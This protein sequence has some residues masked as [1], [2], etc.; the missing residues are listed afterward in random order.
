MFKIKYIIG[1]LAIVMATSSCKKWLEVTPRTEIT[2]D[3][4][5]TTQS[6]YQDALTGVYIQMKSTD[7]YGKALTMGTIENIIS[8]WDVT[9]NTAEQR[10]GLYDFDDLN[11][12]AAINS[13]YKQQYKIIA[14]AN[15]ILEKIDDYQNIFT[16]AGMYEL[17]KAECLAIR[18]YCH[19]DLLRLFGPLPR[20]ISTSNI[21]PYVKTFSKIPNP[22]VSY[23]EFKV[24][25]LNDMTAAAQLFEEVD[26]IKDYSLL[27][28]G[29]PGAYQSP[30]N[31]GDAYAAFRYIRMNYYAVKAMQ[32]RAYLWFGQNGDAYTA[33][34]VVMDA[35]NPDNSVKFRLGTSADMVA[36]DLVLTP[37]HIVSLHDYALFNKY[38][39]YFLAGNLKKGSS[40]AT[41][42]T[43]L[44]GNTATDMRELY[45]W[46]LLTLP[47][48]SKVYTTHKYKSTETVATVA[49]DYRRIPLIRISEMY[50]IAIETAAPAEAQALW[51]A[52]STSRNI[53][54]PAL[55]D[56][57]SALEVFLAREYRKEFF[58]EG[59]SFY[60]YKRFNTD[61]PNVLFT[62]A[63]A[64]I[65]YVVPLPLSEFVQ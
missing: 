57:K 44:Y 15:A 64:T 56:T 30:F 12:Q 20:N 62:P 22:H 41:I 17:I 60:A 42:K 45:L 19:F 43:S 27:D 10:L 5:L 55:P 34:K 65:N 29:R 52:F 28:L 47:N 6:G 8:S 61:K 18:A 23:N 35:R 11:A 40:A 39:D 58:A 25:L 63:A 51:T 32:A 3:D 49:T 50:L 13:L 54:G 59:Q 46:E 31:P 48:Q 1:C 2:K 38:N 26:P 4:M 33:A 36:N 9:S 53:A 14:G 7:A 24:Q 37:E 16:T 21:L